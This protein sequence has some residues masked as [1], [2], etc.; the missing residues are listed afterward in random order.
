LPEFLQW[1]RGV[2]LPQHLPKYLKRKVKQGLLS[3]EQA[4]AFSLALSS[5]G[6]FPS[7]G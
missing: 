3:A 5:P 4:R 2:Y 7:L 6:P 1:M